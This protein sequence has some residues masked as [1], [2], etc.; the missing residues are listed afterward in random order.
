MF[1][2][3]QGGR[4]LT[5]SVTDLFSFYKVASSSLGNPASHKR[6]ATD[7]DLGIHITSW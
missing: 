1:E 7:F 5:R 3:Q 6:A 2:I 4:K